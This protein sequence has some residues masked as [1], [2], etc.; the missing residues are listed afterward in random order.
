MSSVSYLTFAA[1]LRELSATRQN[2]TRDYV[3]LR[4]DAMTVAPQLYEVPDMK[5]LRV[6]IFALGLAI[7][8]LGS[9]AIDRYADA[10][11][12]VVKG[13]TKSMYCMV[14]IGSVCFWLPC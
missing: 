13:S 5:K 12:S 9:A 14:C 2:S 11:R 1:N 8:M 3:S 6:L 4:R 7:P 10:D